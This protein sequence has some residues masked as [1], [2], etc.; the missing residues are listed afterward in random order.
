M[1]VNKYRH[2]DQVA[3]SVHAAERIVPLILALTGQIRSVVDVGGGT[4]AWLSVFRRSGAEELLLLDC[5]DVATELLIDPSSF[6][7]VDLSR[8]L[9]APRRFDL[10]V[11]VEVAEHLPGRMARPLVEWLTTAADVVAFSAAIPGQGGLGHVHL[12]PPGYWMELFQQRGFVR[13]DLLRAKII[14]D[15]TIPWWYRQNLF[16]YVKPDVKLSVEEPDFLPPEFQLIHADI[17]Y[18]RSF[19][20]L[21]RQLGPAFVAAVKRRLGREP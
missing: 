4:G 8:E 10:A 13:R 1:T 14:H 7:P 19:M 11:C 12:Q 5:P 9:P 2:A 20:S 3:D 16:L 18:D 15:E 17:F 21:V 6:E